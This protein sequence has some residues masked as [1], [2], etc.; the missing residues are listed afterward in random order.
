MRRRS[1]SCECSRLRQGGDQPGIGWSGHPRIV[2]RCSSHAGTRRQSVRRR[3]PAQS[4]SERTCFRVC[5]WTRR[6][7]RCSHLRQV[8]RW[9]PGQPGSRR[10]L[11]P[12]SSTSQTGTTHTSCLRPQASRLGR[13]ARTTNHL[14]TPCG[15]SPSRRRTRRHP[16]WRNC[17]LRSTPGVER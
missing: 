6:H 2:R 16:R 9:V 15:R 12:N 4:G 8:H 1:H 14:R 17:V 11:R 3:P 7:T 13:S 10:S 5:W